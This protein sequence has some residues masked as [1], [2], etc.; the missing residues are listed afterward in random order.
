MNA[1]ALTRQANHVRATLLNDAR[2]IYRDEQEW[3]DGF[4]SNPSQGWKFLEAALG[5]H[6]RAPIPTDKLE[7]LLHLHDLTLLVEMVDILNRPLDPTLYSVLHSLGQRLWDYYTGVLSSPNRPRDIDKTPWWYLY[8]RLRH[9]IVRQCPDH[10]ATLGSWYTDL[11]F[12]D[13]I[14]PPNNKLEDD[15]TQYLSWAH[16]YGWCNTTRRSVHSSS[17]SSSNNGDGGADAERPLV[18]PSL[19]NF[20]RTVP[21]NVPA[22]TTTLRHSSY[23]T[24]DATIIAGVDNNNNN[25]KTVITGRFRRIQLE[26]VIPPAWHHRVFAS[27]NHTQL[28]YLIS[29]LH[30]YHHRLQWTPAAEVLILLC[31]HHIAGFQFQYLPQSLYRGTRETYLS[32]D[33]NCRYTEPAFV[34]EVEHLLIHELACIHGFHSLRSQAGLVYDTCLASTTTTTTTT[35][36]TPPPPFVLAS[37][38]GRIK[39]DLVNAYREVQYNLQ[40][41]QVEYWSLRDRLKR[42]MEQLVLIPGD[43]ALLDRIPGAIAR[44]AH[45]VLSK[46]RPSRLP[47]FGDLV[48]WDEAIVILL[49]AYETGQW[50]PL[51]ED[52]ETLAQQA[53]TAHIYALLQLVLRNRTSAYERELERRKQQQKDD[54]SRLIWTPGRPLAEGIRNERHLYQLVNGPRARRHHVDDDDDDDDDIYHLQQ[55]QQRRQRRRRQRTTEHAIKDID[56]QQVYGRD[57][58]SDNHNDNN[59]NIS[60]SSTSRLVDDDSLMPE[61]AATM[62]WFCLATERT[63]DLPFRGDASLHWPMNTSKAIP[64]IVYLRGE[65][66][67]LDH[68]R[69]FLIRTADIFFALRAWTC[70]TVLCSPQH[71]HTMIDPLLLHWFQPSVEQLL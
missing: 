59:N 55:L 48:V 38:F 20:L 41:V 14:H 50:R 36:T 58:D 12:G 60:S 18:S 30:E 4:A 32:P 43:F 66:I 53:M 9:M 70:M 68:D 56:E 40:G 61:E 62:N 6:S 47:V 49:E 54:F 10:Q 44:E 15:F 28:A 46:I 42:L 67:V 1:S 21:S 3:L 25:Q 64:R 19:F 69:N 33:D 5:R 11:T 16:C 13:F 34:D 29:Q 65:L 2:Y 37:E 24:A 51:A 26:D 57:N 7:N 63:R 17:S 39:S 22:A 8:S 71:W 31:W 23:N 27:L 35:T 45:I 52:L